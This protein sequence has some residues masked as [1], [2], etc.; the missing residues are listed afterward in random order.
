MN[1]WA[2]WLMIVILLAILE[3]ATVNLVSIWFIVSGIISLILSLFV[4]SLI[5]Q[6]GVFVVVG[7]ILMVLTKPMLDKMSN[8]EIE[9]MNLERV[10][11]MN[12]IVTQEI[13]VG[14]VGEVKVDGKL[15]SAIADTDLAQ[16]T[17]VKVTKMSGVKL[18]VENNEPPVVEIPLEPVELG[19]TEVKNEENVPENVVDVEE[20]VV[21]EEKKET[22]EEPKAPKK[23]KNTKTTNPQTKK[24]NPNSTKS[25]TNKTTTKK[26][27][28]N[29]KGTNSKKTN[30]NKTTK[31]E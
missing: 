17:I 19:Q 28:N 31:G 10:I 25:N 29:Q 7:I 5:W 27:T 15:W 2:M 21:A 20:N 22:A 6:F 24:K 8:K 14:R 4:D 13:K 1:Y 18:V 9:Q 26:K 16:D 23:A 30:Q 12:G 3:F 11:G